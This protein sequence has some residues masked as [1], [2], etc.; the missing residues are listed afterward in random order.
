MSETVKTISEDYKARD[1]KAGTRTTP[2]EAL[3]LLTSALAWCMAAGLD[4]GFKPGEPM[5]I[6]VKGVELVETPDGPVLKAS[7]ISG[8]PPVSV[9]GTPPGRVSGTGGKSA[10]QTGPR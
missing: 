8:T 9:S 10:P 6:R 1:H 2:N 5:L 4:V 7:A 3:E